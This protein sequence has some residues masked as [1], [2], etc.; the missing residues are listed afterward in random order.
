MSIDNSL[1]APHLSRTAD[2]ETP[3]LPQRADSETRALRRAAELAEEFTKGLDS[4]HIGVTAS[5]AELLQRFAVDL[6]HPGM[7]PVHVVE[8]LARDV[9]GGLLGSGNGRF[10]GWVIG[11]T[12]PAALGADWLV[13]TWDQV[14]AIYATSPAS[15]VIEEVAAGWLK[16]VL[17]LPAECSCAMVTG[18]QMAHFTALAAARSRLLADRG[19]DVERSGLSGA[20]PIRVLTGGHRHESLL[21]AVKFLGIG[22]DA[23]EIID[24]KD[25]RMDMEHLARA[26]AGSDQPTVVSLMAGDLNSG[27]C[28][29]F[30]EA[31]ALAHDRGAWVHVDGAFGLWCNASERHRHLLEG[32]DRA[33][34]W[35]TDGHKWLNVPY[36]I[37]YAFVR[38]RD[39][40]RRAMTMRASYFIEADGGGR[41]PMDWNPEWSRRPRGIVTYAAMRSLGRDGIAD[42][43]DTCCRM[44]DRLVTEI[45]GLDGAEV[46][47]PA[48][49][50]QGLVRFLAP[51]GR[52]DD[53]DA[54]T[55]QVIDALQAEGTCWF[56]GSTWQGK[57]VMRI[58]VS[59][60]R[61]DD[62]DVDKTVAAVGRVLAG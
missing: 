13:S 33:D 40:H 45:G 48:G 34:S 47:A 7:D 54:R 51:S 42:I 25:G 52:P 19:V 59:N 23:V 21:R 29:P 5:Y 9:E 1:N 61:T 50:N 44:A 6:G 43:V 20:P 60:Y 41:D 56:G 62:A 32:C 17:R 46:V 55:D 37:G 28:D 22:L 14:G 18:C 8:E 53:H 4:R 30:A 49:M 2:S 35:A 36:D 16:D 10:F 58:S 12:V 24:L 57:R 11:G 3:D 31:C 38:D 15:A 39:A 26:L 27:K